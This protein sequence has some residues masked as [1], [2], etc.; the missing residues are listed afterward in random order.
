MRDALPAERQEAH[1]EGELSEEEGADHREEGC[2]LR[3]GVERGSP[4]HEKA[5]RNEAAV[6]SRGAG[7]PR[8]GRGLW[9]DHEGRHGAADVR[10]ERV[11]WVLPPRRW[12][13]PR[14]RMPRGWRGST[15]EPGP[16]DPVTRQAALASPTNTEGK[17]GRGTAQRP[18]TP[19][20]RPCGSST[21]R[22]RAVEARPQPERDRDRCNILRKQRRQLRPRPTKQ[23]A[24][25]TI[26][27]TTSTRD[28]S[29]I[30]A[31]TVNHGDDLDDGTVFEDPVGDAWYSPRRAGR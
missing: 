12:S 14:G 21:G 13:R 26:S 7:G 4:N 2:G 31:A 9:D 11:S 10:L 19:R 8:A 30:G 22:R 5:Q 24:R 29:A 27:L 28:R 18:Q 20:P 23:S 16:L 1:D 6:R 15:L 25:S 17:R 3:D